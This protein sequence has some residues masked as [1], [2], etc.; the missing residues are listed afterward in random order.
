MIDW[1]QFER[2]RTWKQLFSLP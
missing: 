2:T 1:L